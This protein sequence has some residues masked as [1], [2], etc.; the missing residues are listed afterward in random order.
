MRDR[1]SLDSFEKLKEK[2]KGN[3]LSNDSAAGKFLLTLNVILESSH[4][5]N[6]SGMAIQAVLR[7]LSQKYIQHH[8]V[9][10]SL[11]KADSPSGGHVIARA[12]FKNKDLVCDAW[13]TRKLGENQP[14]VCNMN[15]PDS[16]CSI[17]PSA[18]LSHT[19]NWYGLISLMSLLKLENFFAIQL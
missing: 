2:M 14:V 15:P 4:L 17:Y 1:I 8:K 13:S 12:Q 6:C 3:D 9:A 19:P 5:P 11:E 16:F 10:V 7:L 18:F